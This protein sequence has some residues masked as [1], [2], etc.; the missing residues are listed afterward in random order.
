MAL[1]KNHQTH[2]DM[3][4]AFEK[5]E[6]GAP[7]DTRLGGSYGMP[8]APGLRSPGQMSSVKKAAKASASARGERAMDRVPNKATQTNSPAAGMAALATPTPKPGVRTGGLGIIGNAVSKKGLL[9]I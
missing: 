2:I 7:R 1:N 6:A 4:G 3:M 5:A 9:G 8:G